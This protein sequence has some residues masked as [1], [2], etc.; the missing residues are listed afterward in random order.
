[1]SPLRQSDA[2]AIVS[3]SVGRLLES[4]WIA[5]SLDFLCVEMRRI[6][7]FSGAANLVV[8]ASTA[9]FESPTM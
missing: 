8:S 9:L 2:D 6:I 7:G 5:K 3:P 1:M 4:L